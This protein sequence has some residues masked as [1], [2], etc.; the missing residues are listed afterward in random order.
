MTASHS[1]D[2]RAFKDFQRA[3]WQ[4]AAAGYHDYF[5]ALTRQSVAALLD[6]VGAGPRVRLRDRRGRARDPHVGGAGHGKEGLRGCRESADIRRPLLPLT[7][8]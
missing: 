8:S 3:G 6:G 1:E 7:L 2:A 5:G 4:R